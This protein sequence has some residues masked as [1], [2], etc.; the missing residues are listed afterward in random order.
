MIYEPVNDLSVELAKRPN[1]NG[2]FAVAVEFDEDFSLAWSA[3]R[4]RKE[5]LKKREITSHSVVQ[6]REYLPE[7]RSTRLFEYGV[8]KAAIVS[9]VFSGAV[10]SRYLLSKSVQELKLSRRKTI[11][12][13]LGHQS[14]HG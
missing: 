8:P 12:C 2:N 3:L 5:L 6:A 10:G 1:R 13:R 7:D 11:V 9:K 14:N 4:S